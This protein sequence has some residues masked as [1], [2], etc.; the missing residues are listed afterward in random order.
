MRCATAISKIQKLDC[1]VVNDTVHTVRF[2]L[3]V[4]HTCVWCRTWMSSI[5]IL[6]DCNVRL[7]CKYIA[8]HIQTHRTVTAVARRAKK[9]CERTL[10]TLHVCLWIEESN[11][12]AKLNIIKQEK[13]W[14]PEPFFNKILLIS[15]KYLSFIRKMWLLFWVF[16]KFFHWI[17]WT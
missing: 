13:L 6:C 2:A 10:I 8:N 9:P 17:R 12:F 16:P 14:E 15:F 5:P 7:Q 1:V 11:F 3:C 4:M